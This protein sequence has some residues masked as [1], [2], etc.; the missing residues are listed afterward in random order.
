MNE[1]C[2]VPPLMNLPFP[3]PLLFGILLIT[4]S[5]SAA[6]Y[7]TEVRPLLERYCFQCHGADQQKAGMN[8][9]AFETEAAFQQDGGLLEEMH[10]VVSEMEMPPEAEDLLPTP[11]ERNRLLQWLE[12]TLSEMEA[13]APNDPG[14]VVMPRLNHREYARVVRDLTGQS[15]DVSSFLVQDS[16]AGE[17]FLNVGQAQTMTTGQFEGYFAAAKKVGEHL[18]ATPETGV[19][20][21]IGPK[22]KVGTE[23][24]LQEAVILAFKEWVDR[25]VRP[26]YFAHFENLKQQTGMRLGAYLEALWRYKYRVQLG[27]PDATFESVAADFTPPLF[28]GVI[29]R[30]WHLLHWQETP[31]ANM[32]RQV[33]Q[34]GYLEQVAKEWMALPAPG[35]GVEEVVR[36]KVQDLDEWHQFVNWDWLRKHEYSKIEIAYPMN[37]TER[38]KE[39]NETGEGIQ[40]FRIDLSKPKDG[41]FYLMVGDAWDGNEGDFVIWEAGEVEFAD[42]TKQPWQAVFPSP[43]DPTGNSVPWGS[44]P[45]GTALPEGSIGVQAP[46]V[47]RM[48]L[49]ETLRG[50]A[51]LLT[52]RLVLDP[53]HGMEASVTNAV[54]DVVPKFHEHMFSQRKILGSKMGSDR[55]TSKQ[56]TAASRA[57]WFFAQSS[58]VF[59]KGIATTSHTSLEAGRLRGEAV[60]AL[61]GQTFYWADQEV[62]H[63]I[64]P[65]APD[66][67]VM[68]SPYPFFHLALKDFVPFFNKTERAEFEN[69]KQ[70]ITVVVQDTQRPSDLIAER[71]AARQQLWHLVESAWRQPVSQELLEELLGFYDA[72]REEGASYTHAMRQALLPVL[73]SPQF[74]Y[75]YIPEQGTELARVDGE[76]QAVRLAFLLWGSLPDEELLKLGRDG[77]LDDPTVLESQVTRLLQHERGRGF[78]EE[79]AGF[80]LHFADFM[81]NASPDP[82]RFDMFRPSLKTAMNEE[83]VLFFQD[84]FREDRPITDVLFADYTFLNEE[85][86]KHYEIGNVH[87]PE[88]RKVA[89][90]NGQRGGILGMG[91]FLTKYSAPLRTSPVRRG[92]WVYESVLG[93]HLP[94]PPPNIPMLSDD[95]KD[96]SGMTVRQQLE[97][98][99]KNPACFSCHDRIDPPGIAL[100]R[101]DPIGRWRSTLTDGAPVDD[102]GLIVSS[103]RVIDGLDGLRGFLKENEDKFMRQFCK[104]LAGYFLGRAVLVTDN[105]LLEEMEAALQASGNRPRAAILTVLH[106]RQFQYRR[107]QMET[108]TAAADATAPSESLALESADANSNKGTIR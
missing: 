93:I 63:A 62:R 61:D 74:L 43:T 49:P 96:E 104:K 23:E 57:G 50:K 76:S 90:S 105:P 99:R 36:A 3:L 54:D 77:R 84:L 98:H 1:H 2:A 34:S 80:W 78:S 41:V 35:P 9:E 73:A 82:E 86:A 48:E 25:T 31:F 37:S 14:L 83:A 10:F 89:V 91:S 60:D 66:T 32:R 68:I 81:D 97:E 71:Q 5:V 107:E 58:A 11:E 46:S 85:L 26:I 95:E 42:G 106:S 28:A 21:N 64:N 56:A 38:A 15:V 52:M 94:P 18:F 39:K 4:G 72:T 17:G 55:E 65:N 101:F 47:I 51:T 102:Q 40:P 92:A 13:A 29:E 108:E 7:N 45:L 22:E 16:S 6:D 87:G 79:F 70:L 67:A 33:E 24:E 19:F 20:W 8:F 30:W 103:G 59:F 69:W 27:M 12:T 44:H 53:T 88:M 100:E 75:R